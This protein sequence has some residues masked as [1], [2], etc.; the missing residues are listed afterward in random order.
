MAR[1]DLTTF[2]IALNDS[3]K[4]RDKYRDPEKRAKLLEQWGLSEHP[5]LQ[6]TGDATADVKKLRDAVVAETGLKQVDLWIRSTG[7]PE[8]NLEY[9]PNA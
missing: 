7:Q 6:E 2:L 4:L 9:D 3:I 1:K 5:A 8:Q